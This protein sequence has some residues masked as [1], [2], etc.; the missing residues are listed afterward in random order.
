MLSLAIVG[1][2]V[3]APAAGFGATLE[4][5]SRVPP[6]LA[7]TTAAGNSYA[8]QD[9]VSQDGR[10][11]VIDSDAP[12]LVVGQLGTPGKSNVF[13]VDRLSSTITLVSH[14]RCLH[15]CHREFPLP[16]RTGGT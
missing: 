15:K 8:Y 16:A 5:V 2:V 6:A 1:C 9:H 12:D 11:V 14:L 13:L 3:F 10:Y 7:S 4:L